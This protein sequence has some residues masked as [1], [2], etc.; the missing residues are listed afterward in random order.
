MGLDVYLYHCTDFPTELEKEDKARAFTNAAW[1][2]AGEYSQLTDMQKAIVRARN[3]EFRRSLGLDEDGSSPLITMVGLDSSTWPNHMF[4]V[5]YFCSSYNSGGINSVLHRAG[6]PDLYYIFS[7]NHEC[8]V[9]PDWNDALNKVN[10]VIDKYRENFLNPYDV[11]TVGRWGNEVEDER[12][13]MEVFINNTR[14]RSSFRSF[15]SSDGDFYLDG[16]KLFAAIK[17][18]NGSTHLIVD[19][20]R[21]ENIEDDWYYQS[22]MI[23]KETIER[24]LAE[25]NLEHYQLRWSA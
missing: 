17:N 16:I 21:S 19:A 10:I 11:V 7:V 24:V 9:S 4:K 13:A 8:R 1:E 5:G 20:E 25:P 23:V 18:K 2:E 22:L 14:A 6:I 12:S 3:V 15:S